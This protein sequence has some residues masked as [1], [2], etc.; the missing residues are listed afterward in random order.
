MQNPQKK[1]LISQSHC[2]RLRQALQQW[3]KRSKD[4]HG[5]PHYVAKGIAIGVFVAVTP[6]IPLHTVIA[7]ALAFI[8]KSSKAAAAIGVWFSNPVTIPFF[9][10]ASFKTGVFLLRDSVAAVDT[11]AS[12]SVS[13]LLKLGLGVTMAT[14]AGGMIVGIF[15]GIAAYFVT[16]KVLSRIRSRAGSFH[17]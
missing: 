6:T 11:F 1:N 12:E 9:Y 4:L 16:R 13:E 14:I 5:D 17:R 10:W 7:V 8:L 15:P 2:A 3:I